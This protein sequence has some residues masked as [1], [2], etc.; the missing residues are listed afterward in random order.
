MGSILEWLEI[1]YD[2]KVTNDHGYSTSMTSKSL[3]AKTHL[4]DSHSV[5]QLEKMFHSRCH[6]HAFHYTQ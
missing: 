4:W 2:K 1:T 3:F 6:R 5:Y